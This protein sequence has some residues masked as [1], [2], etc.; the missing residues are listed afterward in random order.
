MEI[1]RISKNELKYIVFNGSKI[2]YFEKG[3]GVPI[4]CVHGGISDYR[5]WKYQVEPLSSKYKVILLNRRFAYPNVPNKNDN[6]SIKDNVNDLLGFMKEKKIEFAH[7]VGHSY[8]GLLLLQF[9]R[10]NNKFIKSLVL[11]EPAIPQLVF[12][13]SLTPR[14]KDMFKLMHSKPKVIFSIIRFRM[15]SVVPM[16]KAI[17]SGKYDSAMK[18]FLRGVEGTEL[19][20]KYSDDIKEMMYNNSKSLLINSDFKGIS[21][22]Y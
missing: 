18:Y 22:I 2:K 3:E 17:Q 9:A 10:Y 13:N 21:F 20:D 15:G 6:W 12:N 19:F 4:I 5:V 7:F 11:A 14:P 16:E 1:S 8:S